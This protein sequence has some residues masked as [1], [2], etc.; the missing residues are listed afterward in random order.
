MTGEESALPGLFGRARIIT[1]VI[2][3]IVALGSGTN[4]V[5]SA[6]A[7]QLGERLNITHT[8]LNIIGLG[9]NVGVYLSGPVWGRIVDSRGP[10]SLF[11]GSFIL[12][13]AGYSGIMSFYQIGLPTPTSTLPGVRFALLV[14]CSFMTGSGGNAGLTAA[15]NSTAKSFPDRAR[16]TTTGLVLSGFGLSAFFFSTIAHTAFPGNTSSFLAVLALGTACPMILGLLLVRPIPLPASELMHSQEYEDLEAE[17]AA[18]GVDPSSLLHDDDSQTHLL[19]DNSSRDSTHTLELSPPRSASRGRRSASKSSRLAHEAA[20]NIFGR[21]LWCTGDF[22]LLVTILSLLSGTGLMYINNVGAMAQALYVKDTPVFD[23]ADAL[24]WQ[25]AQ[26]STIS[27]MNFSGRILLGLI[28]DFAKNRLRIPRSHCLILVSV[29][30][31]VSQIAA[32]S[33]DHVRDLWIASALLGLGYGC[34]FALF[35]TVCI[36]WFGMP[37]FSENWGYVS[38][39]PM[40][41]GNIFSIAFGRNLDAHETMPSSG[42]TTRSLGNLLA[43]EETAR[44]CLLGRECYVDTLQLTIVGCIIAFFLSIFASWRDRRKLAAAAAERRAARRSQVLWDESEV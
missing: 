5:Y 6:Y 22:W 41:G 11:V 23:N 34:V 19:N 17:A 2:S 28:S 33:V 30:V 14:L 15:I 36:E 18:A 4:Y 38:L 40:V 37:H 39:A 13:L 10:R 24:I 35:P 12:L 20:V 25:S 7:P 32:S 1:L 27:V 21:A 26:V 3:V 31:L 29:L 8:G 43:R 9:G 42:V 16:A 44:Q